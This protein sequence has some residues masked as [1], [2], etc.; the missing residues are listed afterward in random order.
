MAR[1]KTK[2]MTSGSPAKLIFMFMLPLV[3]GNLFQQMYSM[4]D[5]IIVGRYLGTEALAGVGSTGSV[6]YMIIGFCLGTCSGFSIPIAQC[7][8]AKQ[9]EELRRYVGNIIWLTAGLSAVFA[10]ATVLLCK[11][12]LLAMN[13]PSDIFNYAYG[14]I[15]VIFAGIPATIFY[16][17]LAGLLRALGDSRTPLVF[18][19]LASAINIGLDFALVMGTPMGVS[20]AALAT[21]ISQLVS[22][23]ACLIF[24]M[25][26][27]P[28]LHVS[29]DDLKPRFSYMGHLCGMG[30][31]MGLQCSITAIGGILLQS[32]V[33]GLGSVA[34]ASIASANKLSAFFTC[35]Y[36]GMGVAMSTYTGQNVGARKFDR[37]IPGLRAGMTI[38]SIY[39][40][41]SLLMLFFFGKTLVTLFVDPSETVIINN[42][43]QFM[44]SNASC[45]IPLA[46]VNIFRL[47]VQGMGYSKLAIFAGFCEMAARGITGLCLVPAFGYG[48]ACFA[49]P[50]AWI[51]ADIFLVPLYFRLVSRLRRE[52]SSSEAAIP[53]ETEKADT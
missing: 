12:I 34:V 37:L 41:F 51:A 16:N 2:N 22:G 28:I 48:A 45:Y 3:F 53:L 50:L 17:I 8:G 15:V 5:T 6:N 25:K 47:S 21:V 7:F 44:M 10:V 46:A 29:R 24:I 1:E 35:S 38:G 36:E 19:M 42:A 31:P 13:T 39:A 14:Y 27:F 52:N 30:V 20:G 49:N 23:T 11:P 9:Y 43:F 40:I 32:S 4:V 18:L 26:R 33:N